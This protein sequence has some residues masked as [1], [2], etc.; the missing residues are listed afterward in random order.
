MTDQLE[1]APKKKRPFGKIISWV[2]VICLLFVLGWGLAKANAQRPDGKAPNFD[3]Q[4]F[5]G[6]EWQ[7]RQTASLADFEG[8]V[9]VLNFWASWCA[10]CMVEADLLEQTWQEY[11]DEGVVF[12]GVAYIDVEPKS[13]AY[14]ED[15]GITYPNAPDLRSTISGKYE[16]TGVPETFF[17][18]K[19]GRV[20][21]Y[22]L[23]PLDQTYL[24]G[25]LSQLLAEG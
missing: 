1:P 11:A 13:K 10:E 22:R 24:T 4:F 20:A 3:M 2:A 14:L 7:D 16:I 6:Y 15:F 12:L 9:V 5:D 21:E 18:G 19:D 23:G 17:I 25:V 8:Q